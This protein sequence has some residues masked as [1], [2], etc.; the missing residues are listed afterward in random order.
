MLKHI[1]ISD[2]QENA[3]QLI[4]SDWMLI[5]AGNSD[6]CNTMT[7]SYGGLGIL[8]GKPVA[9]IYVRPERYTYEFLEKNDSF[10]LSF[11]SEQYRKELQY[12]GRTSGRNED[13][14]KTCG[15][16]LLYTPEQT[17][18]FEEAR[19]TII[20]KKIYV[21]D[22]SRDLLMDDKLREGVYHSGGDHRMYVG[23]IVDMFYQ[24]H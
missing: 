15:F 22:L 16:K 7:A 8:F 4:G 14:I 18:Y 13:K 23:E 5:S 11:F 3:F 2:F 20:C 17:P 12:C 1:D 6:Q 24:N 19:L 9:Q 10:S 21:Q